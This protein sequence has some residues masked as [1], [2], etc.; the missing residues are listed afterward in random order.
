MVL[1]TFCASLGGAFLV[2]FALA[3][4]QRGTRAMP[5]LWQLAAGFGGVIAVTCALAAFDVVSWDSVA[6]PS[7]CGIGLLAGQWLGAP[8]G[9]SPG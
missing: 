8:R 4:V 9:R 7:G 3:R 2:S 6:F 5:V 1:T